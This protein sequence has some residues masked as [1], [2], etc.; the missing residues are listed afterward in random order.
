MNVETQVQDV[1]HDLFT[2]KEIFDYQQAS[3]GQRF[4]N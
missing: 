4:L 3:V 1:Q 2:E